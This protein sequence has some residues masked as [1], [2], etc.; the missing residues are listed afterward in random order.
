MGLQSLVRFLLPK[1]DLFFRILEQ[2]AEI[3]HEAALALAEFRSPEAKAEDVRTKVQQLE[4][5]GDKLVHELE[6]ALAR[7]FV[8]PIDREDIQRLSNELDT[9]CDLANASVRACVLLGVEHPTPAMAHQMGKL[10]ECTELLKN[11]LP[12]L[13]KH[14]YT[15]LLEAGRKLRTKEKEGDTI[16]REALSALFRDARL[17]FRA[18]LREREVLENLED[19]IDHCERVGHSLVNLSV[20]HG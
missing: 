15:L 16:Y 6:D 12:H 8:T 13:T 14:E 10:V 9:V 11:A 19:A 2:Q 1:E 20:K 5:A 7:T 18:L 17:D 3:A 4:H